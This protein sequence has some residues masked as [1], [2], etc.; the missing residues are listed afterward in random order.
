[1]VIVMSVKLT[2]TYELLKLSSKISVVEDSEVRNE[3]D[4]TSKQAPVKIQFGKQTAERLLIS[5]GF[6]LF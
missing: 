4:R 3:E 5:S 2:L 6:T 1:M